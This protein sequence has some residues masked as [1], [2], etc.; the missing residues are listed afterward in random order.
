MNLIYIRGDAELMTF[1][2]CRF[3]LD[4]LTGTQ[5]QKDR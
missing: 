5:V 2:R 4:T 3:F 1:S